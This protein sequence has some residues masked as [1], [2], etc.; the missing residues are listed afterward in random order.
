MDNLYILKGKQLPTHLKNLESIY[1]LIEIGHDEICPGANLYYSDKLY[2]KS[3]NSNYALFNIDLDLQINKI[4][5]QKILKTD[6]FFKAFKNTDKETH[7]IDATAGG[8]KDAIF[9]MKLGFKVKSYEKNR[10]IFDL[11]TDA[12]NLTNH[13]YF[14]NE[15]NHHLFLGDSCEL[16]KEPKIVY[17]DPMFSHNRKALP[18]KG[19]AIFSE[20]LFSD[21][22]LNDNNSN[23]INSFFS[24][25]AEK[26]I[27][28]RADKAPYLEDI[29]PNY[30]HKGKTVRFDIYLSKKIL[31]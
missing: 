9:L 8:L 10:I 13:T 6:I 19:M 3:T 29:K 22:S 31:K 20:I 1:Q 18:K 15:G 4:T 30:S 14:N 28:K 26:I 24:K 27:V 12:I 16:E 7:I 17:L 11:L 21:S 23:Y 25:G 5:K 2:F